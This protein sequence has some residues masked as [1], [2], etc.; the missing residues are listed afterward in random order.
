M[1]YNDIY[2]FVVLYWIGNYISAYIYFLIS[3]IACMW[4]YKD[5]D[6]KK[7]TENFGLAKNPLF[8]KVPNFLHKIIFIIKISLIHKIFFFF[9]NCIHFRHFIALKFFRTCSSVLLLY[10]ARLSVSQTFSRQDL[11]QRL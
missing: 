10:T 4:Y 9:E 1:V 8:L 7:F 3:S 2:L 6:E 5:S 11:H